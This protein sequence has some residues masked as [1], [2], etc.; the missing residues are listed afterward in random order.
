MNEFKKQFDGFDKE[1]SVVLIL[2]TLLMVLFA[3]QGNP[4][5][6]YKNFSFLI[7]GDKDFYGQLYRFLFSFVFFFTIPVLTIKLIL[8]KNLKDYGLRLGDKKFGLY[9]VLISFLVL[10]LPLYLNSFDSS[11]LK[12]YPLWKNSGSSINNF[13]LW[14]FLYLFYYI[15]WEFFFRGFIQ[16]SLIG[17][18][19]PFF[20]IMLQT[21][22]STIIHIGKPEGETLS[23]IVA[24]IIFGAIALRTNSIFYPFLVHWYLGSLNEL[25][26]FFH[27]LQ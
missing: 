22:P 7:K 21:I 19:P 16:F 14:L 27:R 15:G 25:F 11:F 24:G 6:F 18:I 23:A 3:Y 8:K 20:I 17:K 10:P 13:L 5:F 12:E 26:C 1:S 4:D 9:F 2:S